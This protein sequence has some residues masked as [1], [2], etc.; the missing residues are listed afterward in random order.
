M[1]FLLY[2]VFFLFLLVE[3]TAEVCTEECEKPGIYSV[4]SVTSDGRSLFSPR[5]IESV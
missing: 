4:Y 5:I 1:D 2:N 3:H